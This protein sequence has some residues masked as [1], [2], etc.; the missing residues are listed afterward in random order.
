M[1]TVL[2]LELRS[3]TGPLDAGT[4]ME[5]KFEVESTDR[6][7]GELYL[8]VRTSDLKEFAIGDTYMAQLVKVP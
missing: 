7:K 1:S 8:R 4:K 5:I 3:L 2:V 6:K